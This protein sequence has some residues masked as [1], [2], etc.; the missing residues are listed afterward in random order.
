VVEIPDDIRFDCL[1]C[2]IPLFRSFLWIYGSQA[3]L[4]YMELENLFFFEDIYVACIF[5]TGRSTG[6]RED[7]ERRVYSPL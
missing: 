3:S 4:G 5:G 1:C 6:L 2:C 7:E